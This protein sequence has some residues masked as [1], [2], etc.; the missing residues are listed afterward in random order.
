M[1]FVKNFVSRTL[2]A[3]VLIQSVCLSQSQ[4]LLRRESNLDR[5]QNHEHDREGPTTATV[6]RKEEQTTTTTKRF[7]V[8]YGVGRHDNFVH[9]I[10]SLIPTLSIDFDFPHTD[11]VVIKASES[12]VQQLRDDPEVRLIEEDA[13]RSPLT[14]L[15]DPRN[16]SN[17]NRSYGDRLR[18]HRRVQF[19]TQ[20]A[21]YGIS[22]VQ[23]DLAW[24]AGAYG[25]GVTVCVIDSG[26]DATH[27]EYNQGVIGNITG[28]AL[29]FGT[30]W[31]TDGIGHGTHVT[32]TWC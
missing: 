13:K 32:G 11:S 17:K 12:E 21:P 5:K 25:Q 23:A 22:L 27:P 1:P 30:T 8:H 20:V 15:L 4:L 26:L 10:Q 18:Q 6:G 9:S 16:R 29:V 28:D 3:L 31:D 7:W 14:L 19:G 2:L 24:Q